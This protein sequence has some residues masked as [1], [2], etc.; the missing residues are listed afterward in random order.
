MTF[1]KKKSRH[2]FFI[3]RKKYKNKKNSGERRGLRFENGLGVLGLICEN[4][5]ESVVGSD[6]GTEHICHFSQTFVNYSYSILKTRKNGA[7][8]RACVCCSCQFSFSSSVVRCGC[9]E[10]MKS[11]VHR[12][13]Y[14]KKLNVAA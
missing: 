14:M 8:R 12:L 9:S 7:L 11:T 4:G 10:W 1:L 3:N 5:L 6:L 13:A 2:I